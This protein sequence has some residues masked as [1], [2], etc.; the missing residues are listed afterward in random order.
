[1]RRYDNKAFTIL[2]LLV[3]MGLLVA[4]LAISGM[5]F[6]MA[7]DAHRRAEATGEVTRRLR[8]IVN[9]LDA[10]FRGL[11]TEGEVVWSGFPSRSMPRARFCRRIRRRQY[12]SV[13]PIRPDG[14]IRQRQLP[15][16]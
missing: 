8:A 13:R 10:D 4:M 1:M 7:V 5:V 6:K 15:V 3:A 11:R 12:P 9:Q 16:V 2:E 14:V